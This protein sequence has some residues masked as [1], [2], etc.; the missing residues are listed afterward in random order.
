MKKDQGIQ[1]TQKENI[2]SKSG[3]DP[4]VRLRLK[5]IKAFLS[6]IGNPQAKISKVIHIAGTNGKGSTLAFLQSLLL[7]HPLRI[8]KYT[9]PHL[10]SITERFQINNVC[11]KQ[12][13]F[14]ELYSKLGL[15]KGFQEL[16]YFERLTALAFEYFANERLDFAL[17]ETGLGGRLDATNV[18][19]KPCLCLLTNVSYD[20]QE[21]LGHALEQIAGE[22]AGILKEGVPFITTAEEPAL[23]VIRQVAK[24]VGAPELPFEGF[25]LSQ[26]QLGLKGPHQKKNAA[27]ALNAYKFLLENNES[28]QSF[29]HSSFNLQECLSVLSLPQNWPGRLQELCIDGRKIYLD[30]AHNVAGAEALNDSLDQLSAEYSCNERKTAER[31]FL[32]GFLKNKDYVQMMHKLLREG[33]LVVFTCPSDDKQSADPYEL[34]EMVNKQ[35]KQVQTIPIKEPSAAFERFLQL[36]EHKTDSLAIVTGSLYLLGA[37]LSLTEEDIELS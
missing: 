9:S 30:G 8:G 15:V 10:Q 29:H 16:T 20:H 32:M 1:S 36:A 19:E 17:L 37:I 23:S 27:L 13:R 31:V 3:P 6:S 14:D 2:A 34:S 28:A 4:D 22:K 21:Y 24:Q 11:I 12:K 26:M 5:N 7:R 33:D 25:D 18:I 35:F